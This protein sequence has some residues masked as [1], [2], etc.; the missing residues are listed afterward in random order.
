[1]FGKAR[2]RF[3]IEVALA[4]PRTI[5]IGPN[6]TSMLYVG[7]SGGVTPQ[8]SNGVFGCTDGGQNWTL[9]VANN[10]DARSLVLDTPSLAG[11]RILNVG[12]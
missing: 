2:T 6:D 8:A 12:A 7:T 11:A 4:E 9:G 1:M 5:A 3:W 10:G